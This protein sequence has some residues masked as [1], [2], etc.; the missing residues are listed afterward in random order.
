[1]AM[2]L[3]EFVARLSGSTL[4]SV[5][6]IRLFLDRVPLADCP[7]DGK[8]LAEQLVRAKHLTPFQAQAV[9]SGKGDGLVLGSYVILD[10]IGQGGMGTVFKAEHRHMRRVVALK[11]LLPRLTKTLEGRRRF[12]REVRAA[13]K[14]SHPNIV[15]AYDAAEAKNVLYLVMEYVDGTDLSTLVRTHGALPVHRAIR[16]VLDV[17]RALEYAH[18]QGIIHRDIKPSNLLVS[19]DGVVK[20][21][22]LGLARI[23]NPDGSA[24]RDASLFEL[25]RAGI[26]LGTVDYMPPEQALNAKTVDHRADIYSLGITLYYLLAGRVP[27]EGTTLLARLLAHRE[28]EI[29]SLR[30]AVPDAP[31]VLD[32]VF[33][34]MV[35]K[36]VEQRYAAMS[37]VVADLEN[38]LAEPEDIGCFHR[39]RTR[40]GMVGCVAGDSG[41]RDRRTFM[42]L[43]WF[44]GRGDQ[45]A[46]CN[47]VARQS[48]RL[49]RR[50]SKFGVRH[51]RGYPHPDWW[52]GGI[53][54]GADYSR[55]D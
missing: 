39:I 38:C 37:E 52:S 34:K 17:A 16:Y 42:G 35:A 55:A 46:A 49:R 45:A 15:A 29:P 54:P 22:D 7:P 21:L 6:E 24:A 25:T 40:L 32:R 28:Q 11:V 31:P 12:E 47:R 3:D 26:A 44:T 20:V 14:L 19:R 41:R 13:A 51:N 43:G 10:R 30:D 1:M 18:A 27:Y 9:Y 4:M 33:R 2:M 48:H 36:D 5:E 50:A 8:R 23:D 53:G